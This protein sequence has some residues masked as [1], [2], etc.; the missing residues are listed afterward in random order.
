MFLFITKRSRKIY[1]TKDNTAFYKSKGNNVDVTYMFK[2]TKNGLE[3]KKKYLKTGGG[4]EDDE[5]PTT[6][7][8]TLKIYYQLLPSLKLVWTRLHYVFTTPDLEEKLGYVDKRQ[9]KQLK[10]DANDLYNRGLC[11]KPKDESERRSFQRTAQTR[12][13][14]IR[15]TINSCYR[16]LDQYPEVVSSMLEHEANELSEHLKSLKFKK[17]LLDHVSATPELKEKLNDTEIQQLNQYQVVVNDILSNYIPEV[18]A[19]IK[20]IQGENRSASS[21][22]LRILE[23]YPLLEQYPQLEE[24][25]KKQLPQLEEDIK[26]HI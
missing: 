1:F 21:I 14:Y 19:E 17:I 23:K 11:T 9:L 24:D 4:G 16:I 3:L 26:K 18:L 6:F 5:E 20:R 25:I 12:V 15:D 22:I 10:A 7:E 8:R 13:E 2:K